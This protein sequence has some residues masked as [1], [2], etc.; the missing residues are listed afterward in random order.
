MRWKSGSTVA[1]ER[2]PKLAGRPAK[3]ISQPAVPKVQPRSPWAMS[4]PLS[5]G[6]RQVE[7]GQRQRVVLGGELRRPRLVVAVEA[8]LE[9]RLRVAEQVVDDADARREVLPRRHRDRVEVALA[10]EPADA[11]L[12]LGH[13]V[14]QV[15]PAQPG[16]DG[17]PVQRPR[18]LDEEADVGVEL[19]LVAQR[20]V[21]DRDRH[22]VGERRRRGAG[23]DLLQVAV[24]LAG[25]HVRAPVVLDAALD[26]VR[27]GDVGQRAHH[28]EAVGIAAAPVGQ[29]VGQ[30]GEVLVAA[31]GV[32][33]P[34]GRER[35]L[36]HA[37]L[38][39]DDVFL[40]VERVAGLGQQ[41]VAPGAGVL[42]RRRVVAR[43]GPDLRRGVRV[44]AGVHAVAAGLVD[45]VVVDRELVLRRD[46]PGEAQQRAL[47]ALVV[48]ARSRTT[49]A[50][51]RQPATAWSCTACPTARTKVSATGAS[52]DHIRPEVKNHSLSRLIGPPTRQVEVVDAVDAAR[53][54]AGRGR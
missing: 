11:R 8:G 6:P 40:V 7:R 10:D 33:V 34:L 26:V 29:A 24:G 30:R 17:Q 14:R 9:R 13:L 54:C 42:R 47:D 5:V 18:V 51:L 35:H 44:V 41:L 38:V 23:V 52:T 20:R 25:V 43:R 15:L 37:V 46:L 3:L 45:L 28:V 27:A 19:L 31:A 50:P 48:D 53:R 32:G 36:V 2:L 21:V 22:R 4:S 16:V 1:S 49:S 12:L 39:G